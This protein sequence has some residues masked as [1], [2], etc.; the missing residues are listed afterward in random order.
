MSSYGGT[1]LDKASW[2]LR[3]RGEGGRAAAAYPASADAAPTL[4]QRSVRCEVEQR[5]V[6]GVAAER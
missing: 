5:G 3:A 6:S 2:R 1:K 4:V